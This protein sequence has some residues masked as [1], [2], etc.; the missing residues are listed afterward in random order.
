MEVDPGYTSPMGT[1]LYLYQN[2]GAKT[3]DFAWLGSGGWSLNHNQITV[4]L[5][6]Y[7]YVG[8]YMGN[9]ISGSVS[10]DGIYSTWTAK[11]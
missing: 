5:S 4:T 11:R 9:Y 7:S 1:T 10:R 8:T 2:N 6:G 3:S